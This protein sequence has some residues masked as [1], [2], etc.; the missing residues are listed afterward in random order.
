MSRKQRKPNT[1]GN[2]QVP[3]I[4]VHDLT[5][6]SPQRGT[7]D[8]GKLR[9]AIER[10][11]SITLPR[12]VQL[13]DIYRHITTIDGHLSGIIEKRVAAVQNKTLTYKDRK[14]NRIEEFDTLINSLK[15]DELLKLIVESKLWGI[16][17]V[18][19]IPGGFFDFKAL[20]RKHISP[21][22]QQ[23]LL[24]QY[25]YEGIPIDDLPF[26]WIVGEE[27]DLGKLLTCSMYSLY[28]I[29]GF[30]DFAQYVEIF[31]QPV[32]IIYYDAYDTQTK[33]QLSELLHTSGSS[34]SMMIPKQAQFQMLDGKTSNANGDLQMA[35]IKACND[36]MSVAVLGNTETTTSS[37]SS[38]YAQAKVQSEQ[39]FQITASDLTFVERI[40]NSPKLLSLIR[41]YGLPVSEG[42]YFEFEQA[43]D[44]EK[45]AKRLDIDERVSY[46][47]PIPDDYWYD[48]Y[49]IPRPKY[50]T[51]APEPKPKADGKPD[52][53]QPASKSKKRLLSEVKSFFEKAPQG[54][55]GA[56]TK[57]WQL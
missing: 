6:V 28:K 16:S 13:Y 51:Q 27:R 36:E 11:E 44:L 23:I 10:A 50:A 30:G 31:G 52:G 42:G 26:V 22:K 9:G 7:A 33:N 43:K 17:G 49:D 37:D 2:K 41:S 48:T 24:S 15:F 35:L 40:L 19:F 39:Q 38:G 4:V 32:R 34:L 14:G 21:E 25:D 20:P 47:V 53:K 46:K 57:S 18:E 56:N 3:Q 8:I 55:S 45:L 54:R 1:D 5:L 29:N 12:R